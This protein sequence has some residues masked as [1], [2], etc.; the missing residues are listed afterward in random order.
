MKFRLLGIIALVA[1]NGCADHID[2]PV[3]VVPSPAPIAALSVSAQQTDGIVTLTARLNAAAGPQRVGAFT[4]HVEYDP[5][6]VTY[7]GDG[8]AIAGLAASYAKAGVLRVAGTSLDGYKNGVLFNARF[9][10]T[11][12]TRGAELKL[13]IDELRGTDLVDRLPAPL[14]ARTALLRPWK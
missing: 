4:A 12:A 11:H 14:T 9:R 5:S 7:I 8:D 6:V 10:V 1:A 2:E 3:N 13:V